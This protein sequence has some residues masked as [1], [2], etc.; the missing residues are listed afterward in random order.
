MQLLNLCVIFLHGIV[1]FNTSKVN[2]IKI[3]LSV[4]LMFIMYYVF[5]SYNLRISTI[6]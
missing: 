4:D 3:K 6:K 5:D 1:V 2:R